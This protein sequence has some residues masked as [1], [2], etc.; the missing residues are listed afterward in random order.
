MRRFSQTRRGDLEEA[1]P[2]WKARALRPLVRDRFM[3]FPPFDAQAH[4]S[5][6][7]HYDYFRYAT[8]GASVKRVQDEVVPG[9]FAEVG[10]WRG[11]TSRFVHRLAPD[12]RYYL[13]DTFTGFD[14]ERDP[15]AT[16][17]D[18]FRDT[19]AAL[20]HE[21]VGHSDNVVLK[22][23][24]VPDTFTGLGDERFAWV[25]LDL[26]LYAPTVASLDFFYPRLSPGAYLIVHDYNNDESDWACK[27]ALDEFVADKPEHVIDIGDVWGTALFRKS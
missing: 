5:I 19:T 25:L 27:R 10:V 18:R 4:D 14:A 22:P 12:R 11:E 24:Y 23:G 26:D 20:V 16:G 8:L 6:T 15:T 7:D 13:F 1:I 17:D 3:R 2:K 21:R 9:S